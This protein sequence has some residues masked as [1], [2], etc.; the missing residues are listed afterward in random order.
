MT[1]FVYKAK[2]NAVETVVGEIKAHS[3]DEAVDLIHKLGLLPVSVE[4]HALQEKKKPKV[5]N[6]PAKDVYLFS[7]QLA[8]LLRAGVSIPKAL[9]IIGDQSVNN[10]LKST[11][12]AISTEI[13]NGRSFSDSL[14]LYPGIFSSLYL[15]MVKAGE[16]SGSL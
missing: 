1:T 15:T 4:E 8:N 9:A 7:R 5:R 10:D 6:I 2:K 12:T 3:Q 14:A 11:V 13:K 16:E